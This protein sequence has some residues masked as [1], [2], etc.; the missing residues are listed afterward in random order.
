MAADILQKARAAKATTGQPERKMLAK[1]SAGAARTLAEAGRKAG[2]QGWIREVVVSGEEREVKGVFYKSPLAEGKL[3]FRYFKHVEQ[4]LAKTGNPAGLAKTDF[5]FRPVV[6]GLEEPQE[7]V[8][9]AAMTV[10]ASRPAA[11][12]EYIVDSEEVDPDRRGPDG[13]L[14]SNR[15][16]RC[17]MCDRLLVHSSIWSHMKTNHQPPEPCSACGEEVGSSVHIVQ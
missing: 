10:A 14:R 1:R 4:H 2:Q 3:K 15:K 8:R 17:T 16:V 9:T 12:R 6:L 7:V 13:T 5:N 11:L